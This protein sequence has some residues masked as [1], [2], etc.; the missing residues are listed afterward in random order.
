MCFSPFTALKAASKECDFTWTSGHHCSHKHVECNNT[1]EN[2][3]YNE[4]HLI[5]SRNLHFN[6]IKGLQLARCIHGICYKWMSCSVS[7][8]AALMHGY[9]GNEC[10]PD[11]DK[12]MKG[13]ESRYRILGIRF[14]F[15]DGLYFSTALWF[16]YYL[17]VEL[18]L[19]LSSACYR[20]NTERTTHR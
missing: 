4:M 5:L 15:R 6:L 2:I 7:M 11:A 17:P 16:Y 12:T 1:E 10:I 20:V 14:C 13:R 9:Y 18:L 19:S 8:Q 3:I